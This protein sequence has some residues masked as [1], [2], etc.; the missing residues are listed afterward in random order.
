[1]FKEETS[2]LDHE[3][4]YFIDLLVTII[5]ISMDIENFD[6]WVKKFVKS[7]ARQQ[8]ILFTIM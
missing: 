7:F 5:I 4:I 8:K 2:H 1:M 6:L 3:N